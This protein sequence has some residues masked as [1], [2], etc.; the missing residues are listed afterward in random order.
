MYFIQTVFLYTHP[1]EQ[2]CAG[3]ISII[4]SDQFENTHNAAVLARTNNTNLS[5]M[6]HIL[7][8]SLQ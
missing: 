5:N 2:P 6:G 3:F 1:T 8:V 7:I 4:I